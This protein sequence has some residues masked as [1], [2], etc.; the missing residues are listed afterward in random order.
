MTLTVRT[1]RPSD[2]EGV[3]E[4]IREAEPHR[5]IAARIA[6]WQVN[7]VPASQC[8][9]LL[10]ADDDGRITGTARTSIMSAGDGDQAITNLSVHPAHRGR[11]AGSALLAAAEAYVGGLGVTTLH[12]RVTDDER[13]LAFAARRGYQH[14]GAVRYQRLE[15]SAGALPP[16]QAPDSGIELATAA[17]LAH[18]PRPLYEA[19]AEAS[20]DEPGHVRSAVIGYDEWLALYWNRP[21]LD[22]ELTSVALSAGSVAA[23]AMARTDGRTRYWSGM[24]ATRR[25]FRGRGLAKLVKNDSLHRARAAG[26]AEAFTSNDA[27][28]APMLAVNTWFGYQPHLTEWKHTRR[29]SQSY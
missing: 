15:L 29:L 16:L 17:D 20:A 7:N 21:D 12:A 8:F 10:V 2:A 14:G 13:S 5:V 24:T 18:D 9:R 6:T 23:F 27:G 28:N 19:D 26:Y 11:G 4:A 1:F 22:R 25:A 3:E